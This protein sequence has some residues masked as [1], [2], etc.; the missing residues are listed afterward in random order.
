M[1]RKAKKSPKTVCQQQGDSE[2]QCVI[3]VKSKG[4][5][6]R[7]AFEEWKTHWPAQVTWRDGPRPVPVQ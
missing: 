6:N 5:R 4:L 3:P 2:S 7:T 1:I